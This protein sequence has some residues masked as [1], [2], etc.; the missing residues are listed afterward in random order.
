VASRLPATG[1]RSVE[2]DAVVERAW[3]DDPAGTL[4]PEAALGRAW[5]PFEGTLSRGY[6]TSST[7]LRLRLDPAAAGPPTFATDH[8]VVLVIMPGHLDEIAVYRHDRLSESPA[9]LGDAH[10]APAAGQALLSH[11]VV[12]DDASAP[13]EVLARVRTQSNHSIDVRALRWDDARE[14]SLHQHVLVTGLLV[15]LF[16]VMAWATTAWLERRDPLLG[17]FLAHEGAEP[18]TSWPRWTPSRMRRR[19]AGSSVRLSPTWPPMC[20][21]GIRPWRTPSRRAR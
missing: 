7:W 5:M 12:F 6:V 1:T 17:L 10:P 9:L 13:F 11:S 4:S 19:R 2:R 18:P 15:F 14:L 20:A 21:R 3:L 8:R 16:M